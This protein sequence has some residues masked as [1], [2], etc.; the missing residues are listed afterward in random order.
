MREDDVI[1]SVYNR[2]LSSESGCP[3]KLRLYY[4]RCDGPTT[5]FA[6]ALIFCIDRG[7][8]ISLSG[9]EES[10]ASI[11]LITAGSLHK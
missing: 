11:L 2:R 8:V 5:V 7:C 6:W 1:L 4:V 3:L 9:K 10:H